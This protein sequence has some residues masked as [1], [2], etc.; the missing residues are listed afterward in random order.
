MKKIPLSILLGLLWMISGFSQ[1]VLT[2]KNMGLGGGG[3]S[4]LT[5]YSANFYNPANLLI[6]DRTKTVDVGFLT[7]SSFFNG[8]LN[9]TDLNE[10]KENYLDYFTKYTAGAY[11]I[12]ETEKNE[13]ENTHF[14]RERLTSIHQSR[15]ETLLFGVN[16]INNDRAFSLT[17]RTRVGSTFEIG[18]NWFTNSELNIDNTLHSNQD[19]VHRYQILH[20]FSLGYAESSSLINGLSSRLDKF[21]IGF[22]PKVILAGPYQNAVWRNEYS[23]DNG[24]ATINRKQEFFSRTAGSMSTATT[25]YLNSTPVNNAISNNIN[26]LQ[27]ELKNIHGIGIGVDMGFT[28]LLTF[29]SDLST[30]S[31]NLT[32]TDKSLRLSFSINDI[33]FVNYTDQ[34][35]IIEKVSSNSTVASFPIAANEVFVGVP[36]Q[37]LQ[38][39]E[40]HGDGNPIQENKD[41]FKEES[42]STLL[43]TSFN[44]SVLIELNR[45]KFMGD[46]GIGLSNSAFT[47]TRPTTALGM[48]IRPLKFLP[49]RGGVQFTPGL[50]G[51]FNFGSAIETK[52]WDLSVSMMLSARSFTTETNISGAGFAVLQFHL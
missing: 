33:G 21:L 40:T 12:A 2:P 8:L 47:T 24:A 39:L 46:I 15:I 38:Y 51:S 43:P 5:D 13:I 28:Y 27:D 14:R 7:T 4:Y 25:A 42:F 6:N 44:G 31:S 19:L 34:S 26:G 30:L 52:H 41:D 11:N 23:Q 45:L 3:G 20:E 17:A 37:F 48:E 16:W 32:P 22:A 1:P 49:L 35:L 10:Q 29:G 50:P 18:R 9:S 36:G